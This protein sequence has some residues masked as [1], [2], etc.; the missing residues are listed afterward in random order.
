MGHQRGPVP[1]GLQVMWGLS[2]LTVHHDDLAHAIGSRYRPSDHIVTA[3]VTMKETVDGF[4]AGDDPWLDYLR[5]T[6]RL[7]T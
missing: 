1:V 5:S 7:L 2:E 3:L 4:K 6:G